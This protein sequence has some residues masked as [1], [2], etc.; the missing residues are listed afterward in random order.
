MKRKRVICVF[1]FGIALII[2]LSLATFGSSETM[3]GNTTISGY[4]KVFD[5]G[6]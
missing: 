5:P 1:A 4:E 2:A 6:V 3:M